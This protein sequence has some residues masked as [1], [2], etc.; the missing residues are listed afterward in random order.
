[1]RASARRVLALGALGLA[2]A[3]AACSQVV[4]VSQ[5]SE[6]H[7]GAELNPFGHVVEYD[8]DPAIVLD[9]PRRI[10]VGAVA[11]PA[12]G[13]AADAAKTA[14]LAELI[15]RSLVAHARMRFEDAG[16]AVAAAPRDEDPVA[17]ALDGCAY[18]LTAKLV[19]DDQFYTLFW[20]R[21]R[22][23]LEVRLADL[24]TDQTLWTAR[25]VDARSEA[26][27]PLDPLGLMVG[28][29]RAQDFADDQDIVP[30]MIDDVVRRILATFP[31]LPEP[32]AKAPP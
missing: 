27:L 16:I 19:R 9:Y 10:C 4:N 13:A 15:R 6:L 8:V 2:L 25:H 11:T 17:A 14:K 23:G 32:A 29:F 24:G 21:R 22:L 1:M 12:D 7:N 18:L 5:D 20:S 26:S 31:V 28:V 30:S 3:A